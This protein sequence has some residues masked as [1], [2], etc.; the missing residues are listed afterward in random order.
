LIPLRRKIGIEKSGN[1]L[2]QRD[3]KMRAKGAVDE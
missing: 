3:E 1:E 2:K